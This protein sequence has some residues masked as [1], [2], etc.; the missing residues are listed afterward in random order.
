MYSQH[1]ISEELFYTHSFDPLNGWT[2]NIYSML[3]VVQKIS[4]TVRKGDKLHL[5]Q[6]PKVLKS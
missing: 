2:A 4:K 3:N 6:L 1:I 5:S